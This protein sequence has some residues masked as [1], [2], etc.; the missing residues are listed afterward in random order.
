MHSLGVGSVS[1]VDELC[2]RPF[3]EADPPPEQVVTRFGLLGL[4][5]RTLRI[6]PGHRADTYEQ[7]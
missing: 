7:P 4:G 1:E 5:H 3:D 6:P 2:W